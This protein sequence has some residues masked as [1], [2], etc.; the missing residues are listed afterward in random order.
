[1][2]SISFPK[3][4]NTKPII[5]PTAPNII[6]PGIVQRTNMLIIGERKLKL[7]KVTK[8]IGATPIWAAIEVARPSFKKPGRIFK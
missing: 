1:M 6:I 8:S 5:P 4:G 2:Y 3:K 7:P